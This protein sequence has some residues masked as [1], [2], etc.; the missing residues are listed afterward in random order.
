[1]FHC[2][3]NVKFKM[4]FGIVRQSSRTDNHP[5]ANQFLFIYRLLSV[6]S[7]IKPPKKASVRSEPAR[8]LVEIQSLQSSRP[9]SL[10]KTL[11]SKLKALLSGTD[12]VIDDDEVDD[13]LIACCDDDRAVANDAG[14]PSLQSSGSCDYS[15]KICHDN[16]GDAIMSCTMVNNLQ[17]YECSVDGLLMT[18][19]CDDM[20]GDSPEKNIW[21][22]LGGYVA[23]KLKKLGLCNQCV[24]SLIAACVDEG[25]ET[26]LLILKSRG[27]LLSPSEK[28]CSLLSVLEK[29]VDKYIS[30]SSASMYHDIINDVLANDDLMLAA[31]GCDQHETCMT[32]R[33]IYFYV[34][35]RIHFM[36]RQH[37]RHSSSRQ[38]KQKH[39][40]ISKLT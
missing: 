10:L 2:V 27:G 14:D 30:R 28:L 20:F 8:L 5:S 9:Q 19:D 6:S 7:L 4:F 39:S 31:V 15:S 35:V 34:A 22:Y 29:S 36:N 25:S 12:N 24:N 16:C 17:N 23:Y 18:C 37:N 38:E 3:Y 32:A 11:E 40:K 33:C 1:M 21:Y 26:R 13:L